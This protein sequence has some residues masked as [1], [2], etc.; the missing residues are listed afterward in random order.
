MVFGVMAISMGVSG[1][2]AGVIG[3]AP[4]LMLGG[5]ICALAGAAG[6]FVP[7]MRNAR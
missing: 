4:V 2:L 6:I 1:W 7:A 5:L 3:P